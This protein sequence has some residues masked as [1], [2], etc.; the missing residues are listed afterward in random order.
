MPLG[1]NKTQETP[2]L[3]ARLIVLGL[4]TNTP[5]TNGYKQVSS[6]SLPNDQFQRSRALS[7]SASFFMRSLSL[8]NVV[9]TIFLSKAMFFR[10]RLR[11]R[12]SSSAC[13]TRRHRKEPVT[14]AKLIHSPASARVETLFC[15]DLSVPLSSTKH[16][17]PSLCISFLG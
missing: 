6:S 10:S 11:Q 3:D 16:F 4:G 13:S 14:T 1:E 17:L 9:Q 15:H 7:A 2:L 5:I 12:A 8:G